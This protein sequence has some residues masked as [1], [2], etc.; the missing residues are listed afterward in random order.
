MTRILAVILAACLGL[1][2][3]AVP[4]AAPVAD[5]IVRVDSQIN[6]RCKAPSIWIELITSQLQRGSI[7]C[8]DTENIMVLAS[9]Y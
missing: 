6:A 3:V 2:T 7:R 4:V 8:R 9:A 5:I 1:H